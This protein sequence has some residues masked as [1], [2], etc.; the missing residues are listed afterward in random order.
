MA[1]RR[2]SRAPEIPRRSAS[3][4]GVFSGK[5]I[6]TRFAT[7]HLFR[8][9]TRMLKPESASAETITSELLLDPGME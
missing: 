7:N 5:L 9:Y 8:Y 2:P 3:C 1:S 4:A 6:R